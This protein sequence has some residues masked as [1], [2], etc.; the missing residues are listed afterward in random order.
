MPI[1]EF[2]IVIPA[3]D[4]EG[5]IQPLLQEL[6]T[7]MTSARI[8]WEVLIIDD[9]SSDQTLSRLREALLRHPALRVLT[10]PVHR[11]KSAALAAGLA[12]AQGALIGMMDADLQNCPADF[13][14]LLDTMRQEPGIALLQ[15][16]RLE[17]KDSW[18]RRRASEIGRLARR[19]L[20][21]DAVSDAGC[22]FRILRR[23]P[24]NR[25]PLHFEGLHRFVPYLVARQGG[26]VREVPVHHRPRFSGHSKY[27]IGPINRGIFGLLDLLAVRWMVW[28]NRPTEAGEIPRPESPS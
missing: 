3:R 11:G 1:P 20:L 10:F 26:E 19:V 25:L 2:S 21:G 18:T 4:E 24:A 27:R 14:P 22:A 15:G 23:D 16:I 12:H 9:A 28:R 8:S 6:E 5:N 17:R 13:L 7:I